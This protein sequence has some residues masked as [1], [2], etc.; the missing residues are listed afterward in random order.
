MKVHIISELSYLSQPQQGEVSA[1]SGT[2][3]LAQPT[4]QSEGCTGKLGETRAISTAAAD[5]TTAAS[6]GAA[7]RRGEGVLTFFLNRSER[8]GLAF[9]LL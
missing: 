6:S 8:C 9:F 5:A 2:F 3:A 1:V 4:F 7:S